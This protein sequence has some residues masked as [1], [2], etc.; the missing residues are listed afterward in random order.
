MAMDK[1]REHKKRNRIT[2][3]AQEQAIRTNATMTITDKPQ[4]DNKCRLCGKVDES[5]RHSV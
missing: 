3:A 5:V 4:G 2:M 1:R